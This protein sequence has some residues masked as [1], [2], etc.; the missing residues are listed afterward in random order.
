MT[1]N[2][3]VQDRKSDCGPAAA[4]RRSQPPAAVRALEEARKRRVQADA[5]LPAELNGG[6]GLDPIRY[7]DWEVKGLAT[8]F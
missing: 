3:V 5:S 1:A 8:D 4:A 7:G 6:R 2:D